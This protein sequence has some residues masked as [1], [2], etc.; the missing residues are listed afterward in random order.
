MAEQ[1]RAKFRC[2]EVTKIRGPRERVQLSAVTGSG[3]E[4]WDFAQATPEGQVMLLIDNE[5]MLGFFEPGE[6]YY[7]DFTKAKAK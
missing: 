2:E 3:G 7:A 5:D 1:N 4:D 6:K